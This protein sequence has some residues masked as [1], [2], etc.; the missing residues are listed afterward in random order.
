MIV[1]Q[2]RILNFYSKIEIKQVL[3][4]AEFGGFLRDSTVLAL[5]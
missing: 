3:E 2:G 1:D 5:G 4:N